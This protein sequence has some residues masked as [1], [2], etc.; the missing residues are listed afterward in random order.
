M[1]D[2]EERV[3]TSGKKE[4]VQNQEQVRGWTVEL[5]VK[6]VRKV[7]VGQDEG[8]VGANATGGHYIVELD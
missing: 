5:G 7:R 3:K 2:M 4:T 6:E 8:E 1:V